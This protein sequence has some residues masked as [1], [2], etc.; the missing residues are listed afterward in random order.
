M[1]DRENESKDRAHIP[2]RNTTLIQ[3]SKASGMGKD[4]KNDHI[5]KLG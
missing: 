2:M 3:C 1:M 4:L 5:S